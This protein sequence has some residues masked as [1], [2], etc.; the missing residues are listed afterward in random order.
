MATTKQ[1]V[2]KVL[3][4]MATMIYGFVPPF[5]DFNQTHAENPLWL[6]HAKFHVVWQ[7]II[8]FGLS[9]LGLYLLWSKNTEKGFS[10]KISFILGLIV[11]GGFLSNATITH[12]YGGA[13]SD[14]NGVPP[15]FSNIDANLFVF[16][17]GFVFL[18]V[19]FFMTK[20]KT[21]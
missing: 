8:T 13:L 21:K 16:S 5:A 3:M 10:I 2:G 12:L 15:I 14:P 19:G 6:G 4:T 20:L 11:L 9:L 17:I 18:L 7:V 1:S